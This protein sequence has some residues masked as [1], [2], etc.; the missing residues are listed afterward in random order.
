MPLGFDTLWDEKRVPKHSTGADGG[1][2][3]R[4]TCLRHQPALHHRSE[5]GRLFNHYLSTDA[6]CFARTLLFVSF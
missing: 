2:E 1:E 5:M 3:K 6:R 4:F